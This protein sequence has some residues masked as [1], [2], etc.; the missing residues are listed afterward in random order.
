MTADFEHGQTRTYTSAACRCEACRA[1]MR[2]CWRKSPDRS[3]GPTLPAAPLIARTS[4]PPTTEP[5]LRRAWYRARRC[6]HIS[7]IQADRL[8]TYAGL[9]VL[10]IW[11]DYYEIVARS[12]QAS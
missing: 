4:P 11:T 3:L 8:A 6:G 5:A 1:A 12:E 2:P 10:D 9:H 7:D